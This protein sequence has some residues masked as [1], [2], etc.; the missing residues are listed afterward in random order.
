MRTPWKIV[1][2]CLKHP[3]DLG[4]V[5]ADGSIK[6]EPE[7]EY[8]ASKYFKFDHKRQVWYITKAQVSQILANRAFQENKSHEE[9]N[10]SA[11]FQT[12]P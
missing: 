2:K 8:I 9:K 3:C 12:E 4:V 5:N 10:K 6:I 1:T 11:P 7:L